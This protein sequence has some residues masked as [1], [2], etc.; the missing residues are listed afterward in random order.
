MASRGNGTR[1]FVVVNVDATLAAMFQEGV[2]EVEIEGTF[3]AAAPVGASLQ[4]AAC[5]CLGLLS[6]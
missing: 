6:G 2:A 1:R 4:V 3:F 5:Y